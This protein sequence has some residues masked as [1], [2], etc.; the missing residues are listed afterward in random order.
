MVKL[1]IEDDEGRKTVVPFIRQEIT[2]G[3]QEGNTIRL[4][5]RNVSR[6]HARLFRQNGAILVED[7]GSYNGIRINGERIEGKTAVHDGDLIQI[8]DYDLAI[9]DDAAAQPSPPPR[10]FTP[11][12]E[13]NGSPTVRSEAKTVPEMP[14]PVLP[15]PPP[16]AALEPPSKAEEES[17]DE[18]GAR[19]TPELQPEHA[20]R[21]V[22]LNTDDAGREFTFT[23]GD[24][25]IGRSEE[26]EIAID[27]PSLAQ[28]HA[29]LLLDDSG[30]WQIVDLQSSNG[31]LV[32]GEPYGKAMLR[33]GDLLQLGEVK[34][35]FIGPVEAFRLAG[36][37]EQP[38]S[39]VGSKLKVVFLSLALIVL[40]VD[41]LILLLTPKSEP[42]RRPESSRSISRTTPSEPAAT[43]QVT[44]SVEVA[45]PPRSAAVERSTESKIEPTARPA[46]LPQNVAQSPQLDVKLKTAHSAMARRD[47]QRAVDILE[48]IK[49]SDGSRPPPVDDA[50]YKANTELRAKKKLALAQK[51][52]SAGKT[53]EALR[54]LDE[55]AGTTAFAKEYQQLRSRAEGAKQGRDG[56][57]K[58]TKL[59]SAAKPGA[60]VRDDR[61]N[62]APPTGDDPQKLYDEGTAFYRKGQFNEAATALNDCLKVDPNFARC[63][64]VLGATYARLHE[65]ELGAQHYRRFIQLAPSDPDAAKVKGFL[66]QYES[67]K[68][69]GK[70]D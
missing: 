41:G 48:P 68:G 30:E 42:A 34:L 52:L 18:P 33:S 66:E 21:L 43:K 14:V 3:R 35:R 51:S 20:P 39:R 1:I 70:K 23:H 6:H 64:M 46:E 32:N 25:R 60:E 26:S 2:I 11:L 38:R 29:R 8:G 49:N 63:H 56:R 61:S 15:P 54:L 59:A 4:T 40:A 31:V 36:E 10:P 57:R 17:A 5:E 65:P 22:L 47:F 27:D 45:P 19:E 44:P 16:K 13:T 58:E 12:A 62:T 28:T 53:E 50:L 24:L 69:P 37:V 55:S 7:L 9:Q 67:A